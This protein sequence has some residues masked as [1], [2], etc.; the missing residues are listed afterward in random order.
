MNRVCSIFSLMLQ[1]FPCLAFAAAVRNHQAERHARG[2]RS[3]TQFGAMLVCQFGHAQ[4]LREMTGGLAACE[5]NLR[6]LGV[7]A[8]P[9]RSMLAY[10]NEDRPWELF[11]S[12]FEGF[13]QRCRAEVAPMMAE[14]RSS[15][16]YSNVY[17]DEKG[18]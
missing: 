6:H 2:Y 17:P 15:V 4:T 5:G 13:Y 11:Q 8:P 14:P 1:H 16:K 10:A 12:V 9:K 7:D 3:W 18:W